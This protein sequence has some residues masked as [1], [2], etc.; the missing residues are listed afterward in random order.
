MSAL[1]VGSFALFSWGCGS[2]NNDFVVG[3]GI[4]PSPSVFPSVFPSIIPSQTVTLTGVTVPAGATS[5][6]VRLLGANGQVLATVPATINANGSI[7]FTVPAGLTGFTGAQ[8]L[9]FNSSGALVGTLATV[10]LTPGQSTA[11]V[12]GGVIPS[13]LVAVTVSAGSANTTLT[14]GQTLQTIV[15]GTYQSGGINVTSNV[16]GAT[17][18]SSNVTIANVSQTGLV[19]AL[20]PGNASISATLPNPSG[21][22]QTGALGVI[23]QAGPTAS[24]S[25]AASPTA[26]PTTSPSSS[27][28]TSPTTSPTPAASPS[29]GQ[30]ILSTT[31]AT[32][33]VGGN[34]VITGTI[35]GA[36]QN[37]TLSVGNTG[38]AS[39]TGSGTAT[40]T[41]TGVSVGTSTFTATAGGQ[42]VQGTITVADGTLQPGLVISSGGLPTTITEGEQRN[43]KAFAQF[44]TPGGAV[45]QTDVTNQAL[46]LV[47]NNTGNDGEVISFDAGAGNFTALRGNGGTLQVGALFSNASGAASGNQ[48]LT[49]NRTNNVTV[50]VRPAGTL[51]SAGARVPVGGWSRLF[52][53]WAVY[54]SNVSR[55]LRGTDVSWTNTASPALKAINLGGALATEGKAEVVTANGT[56]TAG[57]NPGVVTLTATYVNSLNGVVNGTH[58]VGL[59]SSTLQNVTG[60]LLPVLP[61]DLRVIAGNGGSGYSRPVAITANF[62]DKNAAGNNL[63]MTLFT[64]PA[65]T[66]GD[67]RAG[68]ISLYINHP[69]AFPGGN[70]KAVNNNTVRLFTAGITPVGYTHLFRNFTTGLY[71]QN[72]L[73][74][75]VQYH[76]TQPGSTGTSFRWLSNQGDIVGTSTA[77]GGDTDLARTAVM[78]NVT[79]DGATSLTLSVANPNLRRGQATNA[80]FRA[81]Y[82]GVGGA[83]E[84]VTPIGNYGSANPTNIIIGDRT[85]GYGQ[86]KGRVAGI[87]NVTNGSISARYPG[88]GGTQSATVN[89][90]GP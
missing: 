84:D 43:F 54:P 45:V 74:V 90:T 50:Q 18:A 13:N 46:W 21:G 61:N 28:T 66:Q 70:A 1:L 63:V 77:A 41:L 32:T 38:V 22:N 65:E 49:V 37:I 39:V 11:A 35:N 88:P 30:L 64:N 17:F 16:T 59:I 47:T 10:P 29:A 26:S 85:T 34:V 6:Q 67:V 9:F 80:T 44:S 73:N 76:Q 23:V 8:V 15:A 60:T 68:S 19:T 42:S 25:P 51:E 14:V 79:I 81:Q 89:V 69:A 78:S 3:G 57:S 87:A 33:V 40:P 2:D 27:P 12:T 55:P 24:P 62:Q 53:A 83:T 75:R 48:T 52:E 5:A 36:A 4:T 31:N 58:S 72:V 86:V 7:T 82:V 71:N 56:A 20:S